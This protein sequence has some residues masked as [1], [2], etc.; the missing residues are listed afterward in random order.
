MK[1]EKVEIPSRLHE[2]GLICLGIET[3]CDE[4]A[5][6]V[7]RDGAEIL[8][9]VVASQTELH[10]QY[11]GVVPELACRA[12]IK[13]LVPVMRQ[14]L[15]EAKIKL[16]DIGLIGVCNTPG[17]IG[18]LLVGV[19]AAKALSVALSKP[20]VGVDHVHAHAYGALMWARS[21]MGPA[22]HSD[23]AESEPRASASSSCRDG[24]RECP[25]P[26]FPLVALVASGGHTSLYCVKSDT[27]Y[28]RLGGTTDDAAGEAFDK[29]AAI[30]GLEYPG[31]P[32]IERAASGGNRDAIRFPRSYL[33]RNSLDFSFSGIKTA[34]LYLCKGRNAPKKAR[35]I[36]GHSVADIAASFQE[37]MV[38]VLVA[39]TVHAVEKTGARGVLLGGG[40]AANARLR[41]RLAEAARGVS[42]PAVIPPPALCTDN[43]A[44]IAGLA[45]GLARERKTSD[46]YLDAIPTW[47][48]VA[49]HTSGR[50]TRN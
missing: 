50:G 24:A 6:A 36:T 35:N 18:A 21:R 31:G 14:A 7:V 38:D 16:D 20:L 49:H 11:G 44:M 46:L 47:H 26:R 23:T 2:S 40:V 28:E 22:E 43:A 3:S 39:K 4:T 15:D 37:A 45:T 12:H 10:R 5:V 41:E 9:N 42:A 34:V 48:C 33:G 19:S 1:N 27:V 32:S 29:V 8:S 30:L 17:L 13:C 25:A